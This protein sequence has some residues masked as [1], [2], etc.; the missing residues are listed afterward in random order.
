MKEAHTPKI[1]YVNQNVENV[2]LEELESSTAVNG[3]RQN[4]LDIHSTGLKIRYTSIFQ[5][6]Y[7]LFFPSLMWKTLDFTHIDRSL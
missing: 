1:L 6:I 3:A 2:Y 5:Y 7:G 4:I